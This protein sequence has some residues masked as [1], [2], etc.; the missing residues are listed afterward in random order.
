M[1]SKFFLPIALFVVAIFLGCDTAFAKKHDFGVSPYI[2]RGEHRLLLV[3]MLELGMSNGEYGVYYRVLELHEGSVATRLSTRMYLF[4]HHFPLTQ[5]LSWHVD[6]GLATADVE[7]GD[8]PFLEMRGPTF[9]TAMSI[10]PFRKL[11]TQIHLEVRYVHVTHYG[12]HGR[13]WLRQWFTG[14]GI[15]IPL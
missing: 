12:D 1:R 6:Y 8:E 10:R 9:A 11:Y 15:R 5:R 14:V 13:V 7:V 4:R 2:L 3:P